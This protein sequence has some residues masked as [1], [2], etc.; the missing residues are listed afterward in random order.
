MPSTNW[1][2]R[3]LL[4]SSG[5]P[6][7][8]WQGREAYDSSGIT[9]LSWSGRAFYDN[10][11]V[12]SFTWSGRELINSLGRTVY[13]YEQNLMYAFN[14]SQHAVIDV[15]GQI[16]YDIADQSSIRWSTRDI[17]A[18]DG[19]TVVA[20]YTNSTGMRLYGSTGTGFSSGSFTQS[21]RIHAHSLTGI[22]TYQKTTNST[23]GALSTDGFDVGI[24]ASG[25]AEIRQRENLALEI[26]T[27]NNLQ[28]TMSAT[29]N[30]GIG[31]VPSAKLHIRAGTSTAGTAPLKYVSGPL[32]T[33][34]EG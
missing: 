1:Q 11:G 20:N 10:S 27:N 22:A 33:T 2:N 28:A 30:F 18:S 9:S 16:L 4:D 29:G 19:S 7:I 17:Y 34:P 6:S 3:Q 31:V 32:L 23:T 26:Y 15:G 5:I 14:V 8:D 25:V 13:S 21:A 12:V 24:S